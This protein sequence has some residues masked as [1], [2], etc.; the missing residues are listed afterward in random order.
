[1]PARPLPRRKLT[2]QRRSAP[3]ARSPP[4]LPGGKQLISQ[5][6]RVPGSLSAQRRPAAVSTRA[7]PRT[8]DRR[9]GP[10]SLVS[11]EYPGAS[12]ST[13]EARA[14][15]AALLNLGTRAG[16]INAA[17]PNHAPR[18]T[19]T[20]APS[21]RLFQRGYPPP[22]SPGHAVA[23]GL[24]CG[25]A[26]T[27]TPRSWLKLDL[28]F[29]RNNGGRSTLFPIKEESTRLLP[30]LPSRP[31]LQEGTPVDTLFPPTRAPFLKSCTGSAGPLSSSRTPLHMHSA[32]SAPVEQEKLDT[33]RRANGN[34]TAS[35]HINRTAYPLNSEES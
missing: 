18:S 19:T 26:N 8:S 29:P 33:A 3:R 7:L 22:S 10:A 5:D 9:S 17:L 23:I 27:E 1:M 32:P 21:R 11:P 35:G 24:R 14:S 13:S 25:K 30:C 4:A 2:G 28:A 16:G 15:N 12:P 34:P 20:V 31:G 6:A